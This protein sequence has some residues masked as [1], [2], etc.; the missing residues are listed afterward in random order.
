METYKGVEVQFHMFKTA[1]G[2]PVSQ[3]G[4][5]NSGE[6]NTTSH[7]FEKKELRIQLVSKY[8]LL[9]ERLVA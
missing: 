5:F 4:R 6:R 2:G 7:A 8:D 3:P 1:F 9:V